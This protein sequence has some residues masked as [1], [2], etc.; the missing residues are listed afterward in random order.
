MWSSV[1]DRLGTTSGILSE[2]IVDAD[3]DGAEFG[4]TG[5]EAET[6]EGIGLA[7][8]V[9]EHV[10]GFGGPVRREHVFNAAAD[11][12]SGMHVAVRNGKAERGSG[13]RVIGPGIAALGI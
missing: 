10:F 1:A 13:E 2:M 5:I 4:R 9:R 6:A 3:L 8:E 7:L 12:V 11:G